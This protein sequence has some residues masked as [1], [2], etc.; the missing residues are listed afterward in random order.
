MQYATP[1]SFGPFYFII[2]GACVLAMTLLAHPKKLPVIFSKPARTL[3]VGSLMVAMVITHFLAIALVEVAYMISV[4]R[5]SLVF[6]ILLGALLF[7]ERHL[8]Q[9]VFAGSL[10]VIGV[11]LI[12]I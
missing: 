11:A 4:K 7:K 8:G 3:T 6:G 12:L 1:E 5:T 2:I 9:H 10:M